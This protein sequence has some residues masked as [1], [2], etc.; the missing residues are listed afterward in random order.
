MEKKNKLVLL[1]TLLVTAIS[2]SAC[3]VPAGRGDR[4]GWDRHHH[5]NNDRNWNNDDDDS[6]WWQ[7]RHG[8]W[9]GQH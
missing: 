4:D 9:N 2:L 3:V 7:R 1:A 5:W 8:N 6:G